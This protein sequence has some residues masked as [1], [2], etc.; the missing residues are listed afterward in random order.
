MAEDHWKNTF[1]NLMPGPGRPPWC[2]SREDGA[3]MLA[4]AGR[5]LRTAGAHV[6]ILVLGVTPEVIQLDWPPLAHIVAADASRAMIGSIWRPHGSVRSSVVCARWQDLPFPDAAFD[7]VCGDGSLNALPDLADYGTVLREVGRVMRAEGA[8]VLRCFIRPDRMESA[9]QV[10]A[11]ARAGAFPTTSAFRL[12]FAFA[13]AEAEGSIGLAAMRD[14]FNALVSDRDA[15]AQ[16]TGWPRGEIDRV[17]F[18]KDSRIRLTFP[19][20]SHLAALAGPHFVIE[21]SERG[22]Y[23]QSEQC[24]TLLFR[25][26]PT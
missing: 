5:G 23:T 21:R 15:L 1:L 22:T 7:A 12:H 17:D 26:R 3:F 24:P 13:L 18:D 11:R 20:Q 14:A 6:R 16:A 4:L 8:L 2:P 25:T 10:V 19:R 9:E